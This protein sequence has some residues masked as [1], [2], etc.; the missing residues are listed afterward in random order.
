MSEMYTFCRYWDILTLDLP[1]SVLFTEIF[2]N[3]NTLNNK[4]LK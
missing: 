1:T 4:G 2:R 3:I